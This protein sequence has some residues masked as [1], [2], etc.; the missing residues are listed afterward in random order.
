LHR[1]G[2]LAAL[3]AGARENAAR[4]DWPRI[5]ARCQEVYAAL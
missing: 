1:P 3:G 2:G 5:A 4:F